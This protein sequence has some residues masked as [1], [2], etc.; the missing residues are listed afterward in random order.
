[1]SGHSKWHNIQARKGKADAA[2]G[3]IFTKIGREIA[4]A[5][6][7]GGADPNT[8][9]TLKSVIAKAKAANMPND[10]IT[11]SIK[12]ASGE[13]GAINYEDK[14]YEGYGTG[15]VAV[16]VKCLT[17]NINR[18]AGDVRHAFDKHNGSLGATGCV[19]YMFRNKS[20]IVIEKDI[21]TDVDA[22][23]M[24]ALE[25]GAIDVVDCEDVIEVE[26]DTKSLTEIAEKLTNAGYKV[27][28]SETTMVADNYVDLDEKQLDTFMKM[29]DEL[30]E[31]DDVQ[32]VFHNANLPETEDEE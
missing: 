26:T 2:R 28:S 13:L 15:G 4:V 17:D 1:M 14:I 23:M 8:N 22:V 16:I 3:N 9:N 29:L 27:I 32:E 6:K 21:N 31:N 12:K 30:E 25:L 18:T 10:N 5:V 19:S 20:V 11:R 7:N 24:E